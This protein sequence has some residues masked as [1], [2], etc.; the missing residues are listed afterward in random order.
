MP[1]ITR[2]N[3]TGP[4]KMTGIKRKLVE[5][6]D[7]DDDITTVCTDSDSEFEPDSVDELEDTLDDMKEEIQSLRESENA[8]I[9]T[10]VREREKNRA[11]QYELE[12]LKQKHERLVES[13]KEVQKTCWMEVLLL[14]TILAATAGSA[15]AAYLACS[16]DDYV[17]FQF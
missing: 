16:E 8:L 2:S 9:E 4:T 13:V 17:G 1:V 12:T 7:S 11:L 5:I 14:T 10:I 15:L 6:L 3:K